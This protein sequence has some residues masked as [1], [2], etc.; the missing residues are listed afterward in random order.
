MDRIMTLMPIRCFRCNKPLLGE[1]KYR[2]LLREDPDHDM[3]RVLTT[4][5]YDKYCCRTRF[6]TAPC[7]PKHSVV[8]EDPAEYQS[9]ARPQNRCDPLK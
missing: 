2:Q 4:M 7:N 9:K 6:I 3:G 5:G 1:I 8:I